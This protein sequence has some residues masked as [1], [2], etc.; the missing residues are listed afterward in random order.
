MRQNLK[1]LPALQKESLEKE[2]RVTQILGESREYSQ[3]LA[4][5]AAPAGHCRTVQ[6]FEGLTCRR[7]HHNE[8]K[9]MALD[10]S[11]GVALSVHRSACFSTCHSFSS[12]NFLLSLRI[13]T[14]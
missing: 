4:G 3:L 14:V 10:L 9:Q 2:E 6:G 13:N 7:S 1:F 11:L 8:L 5:V 12:L